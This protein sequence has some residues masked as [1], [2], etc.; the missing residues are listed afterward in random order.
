MTAD[1]VG[2]IGR[3][4]A[5]ADRGL[6]VGDKDRNGMPDASF[7]FARSDVRALFD[8]VVGRRAVDAAVEG[9]LTN[10]KRFHAPIRI[11]VVGQGPPG[12]PGPARVSPNPLNPAGM[13]WFSVAREGPVTVSLFD[14]GG[15]LVRRLTQGQWFIAGRHAL[16]VGEGARGGTR[17]ASGVYFFSVRTVDGVETGRFVVLK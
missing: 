12:K 6:R 15:R 9:A 17:F 10:G 1:G 14:A 16:A 4:A 2:S 8:A 3:I 5:V 7:A 11:D 13:L